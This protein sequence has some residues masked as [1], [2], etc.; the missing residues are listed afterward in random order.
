MLADTHVHLLAGLDDGPRSADEAAA[1]CRMLV[2]EGARYAAAVAHQNPG[3][4]DN[5][6]ARLAAATAA[7]AA[8]LAR[9]GVPLSVAPTG[10]VMLSADTPDDWRAGRLQSVGGH[11]QFLLVEQPHGLFLDARPLAAAVAAAGVRVVVAHAERYPELVGDRGLADEWV[12]AGCLLQITAEALARPDS[13]R[14]AAALK[15]WAKRG[16]IHLLG[17][18][19]HGVGRREPRLRAGV[20][21]LAR[22]AGPAAADRAAGIWGPAVVL[23]QAVRVP[24]PAARPRPGWFGRLFGG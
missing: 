11:G 19:G 16:L 14:Q 8:D 7:L 21:V 9:D 12:R 6:P 22:W 2:A 23:G 17:S 18:D 4:P 1:M 10:E 5:T 15:D 20:E 3:Y 24:P 13:G